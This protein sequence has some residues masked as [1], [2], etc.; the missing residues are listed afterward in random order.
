M[1]DDKMRF[2]VPALVAAIVATPAIAQPKLVSSNP[3]AGATIAPVARIEARFSEPLAARSATASLKMTG[4][5]GMRTHAPM[6]MKL[7]VGLGPDGATLVAATPKP[8]PRGT[9][10]LAYRVAS[11]A[12]EDAG[13]IGFKVE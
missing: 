5:P 4:M 10:V 9:Y 12:G 2:I 1:K 13:E 11:A 7:A 8:L 6:T 3:A